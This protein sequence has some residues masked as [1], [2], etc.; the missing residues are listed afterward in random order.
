[1]KIEG[2]STA[3]M[4]KAL[5]L[6]ASILIGVGCSLGALFGLLGQSL[7][8][9]ALTSVTGFPVVY[10]MAATGALLTALAV[11]LTAVAI[12]GIFGQRAASVTPES[13][14]AG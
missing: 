1:M 11:T 12:V 14:L 7:L 6:E 5:L 4:W 2:Y 8:S 13:S 10:S 9:R 3:D